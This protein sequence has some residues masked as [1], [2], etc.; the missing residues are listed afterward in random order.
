MTTLSTLSKIQENTAALKEKL[1]SLPL[2]ARNQKDLV[3]AARR[4]HK[5]AQ[6]H[7]NELVSELVAAI[8]A[9]MDPNTGKSM[10]SNDKARDAELVKRKAGSTEYKTSYHVYCRAEQEYNAAKFDLERIYDE[11]RAVEFATDL[12]AREL[13]VV[14]VEWRRSGEG[15]SNSGNSGN[16]NNGSAK[17]LY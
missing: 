4:A 9:E 6:T 15:G 11:F 1:L 10:F 8:G 3:E 14:A 16:V 13:A 7:V 17:E 12:T 2:L 5:D